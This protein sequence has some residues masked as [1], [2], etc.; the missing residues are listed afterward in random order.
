VT[1]PINPEINITSHKL[2]IWSNQPKI[3]ADL[4]GGS[5]SL[6]GINSFLYSFSAT[7]SANPKYEEI[8]NKTTRIEINS[9][10]N[11]TNSYLR[12]KTKDYAGNLSD[13]K[14]IGPFM[15]DFE[16]PLASWMT[17]KE[18]TVSGIITL[19]IDIVEDENSSDIEYVDYFYKNPLGNINLLKS[20]EK[21]PYTYIFNTNNLVVLGKYSLI[22][23]VKDL[24]GN[25]SDSIIDID[26]GPSISNI[27]ASS[28]SNKSASVG[29]ET[30]HQATSRVVFDNISHLIKSFPPN[31]GYTYST[32]EQN[33]NDKKLTH[34]INLNGLSS[35]QTY[36]YR[37]IARGSPEI[38]SEEKTFHTAMENTSPLLINITPIIQN[39]YITNLPQPAKTNIDDK[40]NIDNISIPKQEQNK[41]EVLGKN[42]E[43][44]SQKTNY[45]NKESNNPF[46]KYFIGLSVFTG[47]LSLLFTINLLAGKFPASKTNK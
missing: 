13:E 37:V 12:F 40:I 43:A 10:Q 9:P 31:Y 18:T 1:P 25:V 45:T 3:V 35:N 19:D 44:N 6:S 46:L 22:A 39:T 33:I 5:D 38:V 26:I 41:P 30:S 34:L 29:W 4:S 16:K 21:E 11:S 23:S 20:I 42:V 8:D 2:G 36:Y 27:T 15:L 7:I 14:T 24:A 32:E 28:L 17:P 47:L